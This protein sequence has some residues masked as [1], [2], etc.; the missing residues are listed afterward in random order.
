[1][2]TEPEGLILTPNFG[3]VRQQLSPLTY[4]SSKNGYIETPH[5]SYIFSIAQ[6]RFVKHC[7]EI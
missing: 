5:Y 3:D 7:F 4:L 1:M 2:L 6:T